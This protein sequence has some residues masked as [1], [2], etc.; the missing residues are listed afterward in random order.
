MEDVKQT[1]KKKEMSNAVRYPLVLGVVCLICGAI[2]ASVNAITAP[3]IAAAEEKKANQALYDIVLADG[4]TT[5]ESDITA[6][7]LTWGTGV[8]HAYLNSRKKVTVSG[9]ANTYYYYNATSAKG[10][11]GTITFGALLEAA[12]YTII[13]YKYLSSD[14]DSIGTT[15][16]GKIA[17]TVSSPY[18]GS[19]AVVSGAS[20]SKTLPAIKK[21]FDAIIADAKAI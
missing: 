7:D 14:E 6:V 8:E 2:L 5:S 18:D 16:A 3:V 10:Y 11:S 15:A 1:P 13:G 9:D 12:N 21:A 17:Y 4:L 19:G 20:A